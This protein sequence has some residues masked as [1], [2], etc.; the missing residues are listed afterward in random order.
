M[1]GGHKKNLEEAD[2]CEDVSGF[3]AHG[4]P[5]LFL[6]FHSF[7]CWFERESCA[8]Q[9]GCSGLNEM[10]TP[11]APNLRHLMT[12][13]PVGGHLK[14]IRVVWPFGGNMSLGAML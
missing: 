2:S 10:P 13:S 5:L 12:W 7:V 8:A 3:G 4:L 1:H 11:S 6:G 9:V 14:R